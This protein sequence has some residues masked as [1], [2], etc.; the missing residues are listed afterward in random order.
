MRITTSPIFCNTINTKVTKF[1]FDGKTTEFSTRVNTENL[2]PNKLIVC[3]A[4]SD[5][6]QTGNF[7]KNPFNFKTY[8]IIKRNK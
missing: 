6:I 7:V 2:V 5:G 8:S 4:D 1:S 3:F